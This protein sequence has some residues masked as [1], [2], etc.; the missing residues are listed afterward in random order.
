[1]TRSEL[2]VKISDFEV[3]A[4]CW[5]DTD[6]SRSVPASDDE[7]SEERLKVLLSLDRWLLLKR[8]PPPRRG[9][10]NGIL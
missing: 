3:S 5:A 2:A 6:E 10:W 8:T 9:A 7:V 4:Q 1:M